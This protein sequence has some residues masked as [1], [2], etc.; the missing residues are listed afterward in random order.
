MA[1]TV[2]GS[3]GRTRRPKNILGADGTTISAAQDGAMDSDD[4]PVDD[5]VSTIST[6]TLNTGASAGRVLTLIVADDAFDNV[7]VGSTVITRGLHGR[8]DNIP[9]PILSVTGGANT[10]V[11]RTPEHLN[12]NEARNL[13]VAASGQ[14]VQQTTSG[15]RTENARFLHIRLKNGGNNGTKSVTVYGYNYAFGT[16]HVLQLPL[17]LDKGDSAIAGDGTAAAVSA[18]TIDNAFADATFFVA[19]STSRMLTLPINGMDRVY[20]KA[21]AD[22]ADITLGAAISTF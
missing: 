7:V 6:A 11:V 9:L 8:I 20:F 18:G 14:L 13:R 12:V 5:I 21:S 22:H 3:W 4:S 2:Y 19:N 17:S 1:N 16:W 10:V 15:Y